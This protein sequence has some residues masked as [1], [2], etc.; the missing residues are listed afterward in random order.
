MKNSLKLK[1]Q[2]ATLVEELQA[3]VDLATSEDRD[4][5]EAEESRQNEI[6]A[7]VN[8]LD[9]KISK[10][11]ETEKILLR[12]AETK[13]KAVAVDMGASSSD[14]R[15]QENISKRFSLTE[16]IR[17]LAQGR[18]LDGVLREMDQEARKE[19]QESGI[20]L[21]GEF[22]VPA[23]L[24]YGKESRGAYGVSSADANIHTSANIDKVLVENTADMAMS[25]QAKSVVAAA[26]ATQLSG[27]SGDVK[28]PT[29]P[30]NSVVSDG[31]NGDQFEG[32][33][34]IVGNADFA[35]VTL[36]PT[37]FAGAVDISK[38]LIYSANG[39]LDDLF[40]RD[41]GNAIASKFDEHVL[42]KVT[43]RLTAGTATIAQGRMNA[44]DCAAT[45]FRDVGALVGKY[46]A[47]NPDDLNRAFFLTPEMYGYLLGQTADGGGM[48]QAANLQEQL[49]GRPAFITTNIDDKTVL[50]AAAFGDNDVNDTVSVSPIICADAS[51]IFMCT[52]AGLSIN[53][54]VYTEALKGVVRVI[55][56]GY[57]DGNLRRLGSAALLGGLQ[58][59]TTPTSN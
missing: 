43:N 40:G 28:L 42:A 38:H 18:P 58:V 20:S 51:D 6:H 54:D 24:S 53:V 52:W 27:F 45:N 25:L 17:S 44:N 32:D 2:R 29:M 49:M 23:F 12:N 5:T 1:E 57:M 16:G 21:R 46:L 55:A 37:R 3:A 59:D 30:G 22:N 4:F 11:E 13:A 48:I 36:K 8:A 26:G 47:G 15:E 19:A 14:K 31:G 34:I 41:L 35:G 10:A 33:A 39:Q 9:G 56:D 7:E 50:T